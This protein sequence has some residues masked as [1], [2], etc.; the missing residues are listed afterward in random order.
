MSPTGNQLSKG[1]RLQGTSYSHHHG[2]PLP[3]GC[4]TFAGEIRANVSSPKIGYWQQSRE[5]IPT[6]STLVHQ[7]VYCGYLQEH[8]WLIGSYSTRKP[9]HHGNGWFMKAASPEF[10]AQLAGSYCEVCPLLSN[11][12]LLYNLG[13]DLVN[14]CKCWATEPGVY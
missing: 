11:C 13:E 9:S 3:Q 8:G 7:W 2:S 4:M 6:K 12:L 14:Q 1:L 5:A 10:P